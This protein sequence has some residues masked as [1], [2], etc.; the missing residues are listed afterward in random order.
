MIYV[1]DAYPH[2]PEQLAA[3]AHFTSNPDETGWSAG[4][5]DRMSTWANDKLKACLDDSLR[6][7]ELGGHDGKV[8]IKMALI[9]PDPARFLTTRYVSLVH[10]MADPWI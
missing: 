8:I 1:V 9:A 4:L 3:L 5:R 7:K 10:V 2:L 6:K